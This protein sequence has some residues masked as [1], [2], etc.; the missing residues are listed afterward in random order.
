MTYAT[1]LVTLGL[2]RL[3]EGLAIQATETLFDQSRLGVPV[4]DLKTAAGGYVIDFGLGTPSQN[5]VLRLDLGWNRLML[6]SSQCKDTLCQEKGRHKFNEK[7]STTFLDSKFESVSQY[8]NTA[9]DGNLVKDIAQFGG[10]S[11]PGLEFLDA[12]YLTT[13]GNFSTNIPGFDGVFGL[14]PFIP[15]SAGEGI[16]SPLKRLVGNNSLAQNIFSLELPHG[17]QPASGNRAEGNLTFG[18]SRF[19][20]L[21]TAIIA[22]PISDR[23]FR[24]NA[25]VLQANNISFGPHIIPPDYNEVELSLD[26]PGIILPIPYAQKINDMIKL[27][28]SKTA[29]YVVNCEGRS[30][31]PEF[32]M[33]VGT[34]L[35]LPMFFRLSAYEYTI[36]SMAGDDNAARCESLFTESRLPYGIVL[37]SAVLEKYISVWDLDLRELRLKKL[38][39]SQL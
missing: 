29:P 33:D 11:I 15:S 37:G 2:L 16:T 14:A 31:M 20:P 10:Y 8:S 24:R 17:P 6:P 7:A 21:D 13:D 1:F 23:S 26:R 18:I 22:L 36:E 5:F 28:S 25:W 19:D 30:D 38:A 34:S 9:F 27:P 4:K 35:G 3:S 39:M 32:I 12:T